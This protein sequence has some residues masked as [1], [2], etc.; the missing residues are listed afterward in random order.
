MVFTT[1]TPV[2]EDGAFDANGFSLWFGYGKVNAFHAVQAASAAVAADHAIVVQLDA[3]LPSPA[4]G[5][6]V[7]SSIDIDADGTVTELRVQ[8]DITHTYI[9]DLRVDLIAPD[10]SVVV[11][12]NN[13][14]GSKD[15]LARTYSV[16]DTPALRPLLDKPIRGKWQLRVKDTFRLDLG[17]L[18][19]WRIAA[20]VAS[21]HTESTRPLRTGGVI[22]KT[23]RV[24]EDRK[25]RA[26]N[27]PLKYVKH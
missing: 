24:Q 1:D 10:N 7:N 22:H 5:E 8:V 27:G 18:N 23:P 17:R 15:N 4:V 19:R 12:H 13:T 26:G 25:S 20:R 6:P 21:P 11:L 14:G 16:R 3:T 2:N 9:G